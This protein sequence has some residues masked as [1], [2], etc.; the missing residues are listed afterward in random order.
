MD[1]TKVSSRCLGRHETLLEESTLRDDSNMAS[2]YYIKE[3]AKKSIKCK[4]QTVGCKSR[5]E[6]RKISV[7]D[8]FFR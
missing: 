8:F 7:T 5:S 1:Q 4:R 6:L 3:E 2:D